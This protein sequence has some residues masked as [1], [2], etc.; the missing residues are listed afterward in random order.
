[1]LPHGISGGQEPPPGAWTVTC[2]PSTARLAVGAD[3]LCS[4][5]N[6]TIGG[7]DEVVQITGSTAASFTIVAGPGSDIG[8]SNLNA[9]EQAAF[10][11]DGQSCDPND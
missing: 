9:A 5:F 8:C 2:G 3:I 11:A 6:P 1:M 7:A 10:T 4:Q